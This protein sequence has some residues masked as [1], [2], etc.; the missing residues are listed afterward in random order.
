VMVGL[1]INEA[2]DRRAPDS[3]VALVGKSPKTG[4]M[5]VMKLTMRQCGQRQHFRRGVTG[6]SRSIGQ[7]KR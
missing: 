3:P 6:I 4:L 2:F 7:N 1:C 5:Q